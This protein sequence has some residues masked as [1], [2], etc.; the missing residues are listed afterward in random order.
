MK[1]DFAVSKYCAVIQ[2]LPAEFDNSHGYHYSCYKNFTAI[3][4]DDTVVKAPH[5]CDSKKT[6]CSS[7]GLPPSAST[8]G[9]FPHICIFCE[10][11]RKKK[12]GVEEVLGICDTTEAEEKIR[13]AA[14]AKQDRSLLAKITGVNFRYKEMR[15]HHSC[16][17]TYLI[18]FPSVNRPKMY[19]TSG[20][21]ALL[22]IYT[23]IEKSI[24][25]DK[26]P[27]LLTS[28]YIRYQELLSCCL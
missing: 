11:Q 19:N 13:A 25:L 21:T 15:Y 3:P 22:G 10:K 23:Y 20:K 8:K 6:P 1:V 5:L 12:G 28:I 27:E 17:S 7:T 26:R 4:N 2:S 16:R 14:I 9:V 24:I 18:N